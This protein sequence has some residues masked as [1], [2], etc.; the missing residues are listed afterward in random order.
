[1]S[2]ATLL[3]SLAYRRAR[4]LVPL[5]ATFSIL[6]AYRDPFPNTF[7]VE[8]NKPVG[9]YRSLKGTDAICK[10]SRFAH[11]SLTEKPSGPLRSDQ[12]AW[13]RPKLPHRESDCQAHWHRQS[14]PTQCLF[15]SEHS[16]PKISVRKDAS[17]SY[18]A[19]RCPATSFQG[20]QVAVVRCFGK[21]RR[22]CVALRFTPAIDCRVDKIFCWAPATC[23]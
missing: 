6:E 21:R 8:V 5:D 4:N 19:Q 11:P 15:P 2:A 17:S 18:R 16:A 20:L 1:M 12:T 13:Q 10:V 14:G 22:L 23:A 9:W 3:C 7:E